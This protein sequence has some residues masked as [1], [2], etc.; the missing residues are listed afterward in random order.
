MSRNEY[1]L[2]ELTWEDAEAAYKQADFVA[3]P[4]GSHE[5]HS[6][7]LPLAVDSIRAEEMTNALIEAAT[8]HGLEIYRLPVLQYGQSEHHMHF[9]GTV[10]IAPR[11]YE[12]SLIEIGSSLARHNV[13]R[14]LI[15][16]CHGGNRAPI[17]TAADR[18]QREYGLPT[19][20]INWTSYAMKYLQDEF[21]EQFGEWFAGE[22]PEWGHAGDHETSIIELY[23][24]DL[25]KEDKKEDQSQYPK[26]KTRSYEYFEELTDQGGL[27]DP[28]NSDPEFVERMI[29]EATT[30]M[31][32]DLR[33][34]IDDRE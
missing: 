4:T 3:L 32:E 11:V 18:L 29:E 22:L 30:H 19:H 34:D 28:R 25:V 10:S 7:H 17:D 15:V 1:L 21:E 24:P 6:I 14:F 16:N 9:P 23:R 27:G 20:V 2:S 33:A 5:Q 31:L 13:D 26:P 8:D 12:D